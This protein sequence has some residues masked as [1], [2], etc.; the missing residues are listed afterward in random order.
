MTQRWVAGHVPGLPPEAL[1]YETLSFG[2]ATSSIGDDRSLSIDVPALDA[3]QMSAV[4]AHV[5]ASARVT[6]R[7]MPVSQII[8]RIDRAVLRL[9]DPADTHRRDLDRL[10]PAVTGYDAEMIRLGL[11][12]YLQAFRA[13]EL[14]RFVA[15]DFADRKSVV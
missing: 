13:T 4:A 2:G 8:E 14:H 11:N 10:L 6:L 7:S 5:R 9:L 15:E 1:R 3:A 12:G